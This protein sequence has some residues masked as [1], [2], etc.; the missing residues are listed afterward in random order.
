LTVGHH[1]SVGLLDHRVAQL[2]DPF[3][4]DPHHVT[5]L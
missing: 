2:A 1:E 5:D 3:D 4:L